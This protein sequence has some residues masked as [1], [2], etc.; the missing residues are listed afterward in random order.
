MGQWKLSLFNSFRYQNGYHYCFNSKSS[1]LFSL[2]PREYI[3][4]EKCLR[5]IEQDGYG[6]Y[7][8]LQDV[9][10][11]NTFVVPRDIDEYE[12]E[13]RL[14]LNTKASIDYA[15]LAVVPTLACNMKCSYCFQKEIKQKAP[16]NQRTCRGVVEMVSQLAGKVKG[17]TVLWFGGEPF[18]AL[19]T[20]EKLSGQF[21]EI[22][23][24]QGI[25][26]YAEMI[27][28]G[29]LLN[30]ETLESLKKLNLG[31]LEISLDG[32]PSSYSVRK[33]VP[34]KKA[35]KFYDFLM[36]SATALLEA[37]GSL[38]IH[39]NVDRD[40]IEEAKEIVLQM[41]RTSSAASR[42]DFHLQLLAAGKGLIECIPHNCYSQNEATNIE[43]DFK[44]FL[45]DEGLKV[46][47]FPTRLNHPCLAVRKYGYTIDP[48]GK[49]GKCVPVTGRTDS[50]FYAINPW[51]TFGIL[52]E[53]ESCFQPYVDFDPFKSNICYQCRFLPV[54]LGQCPKFHEIGDFICTRK[55]K[56]E[57]E[58]AFYDSIDHSLFNA[59]H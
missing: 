8:A 6:S 26:Y 36:N 59:G 18:L 4:F 51:N 22:C 13:H 43:L 34:L 7:S 38:K 3:L 20:I 24:K 58:L 35:L 52:Q 5:E 15:F 48:A 55:Q 49:I 42:I 54:C 29:S 44:K 31:Q 45:S 50:T 56:F 2:S 40:N 19:K 27:T 30:Q 17:I 9:L 10:I 21:Q 28:N 14:F 47:G 23:R 32:L 12:Q 46:S 41:K 57:N 16:M 11:R 1:T 25:S 37:V 33:G 39:L 53:L